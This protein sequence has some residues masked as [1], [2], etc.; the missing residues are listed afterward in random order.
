[1]NAAITAIVIVANP[2]GSSDVAEI[3][4]ASPLAAELQSIAADYPDGIP[5]ASTSQGTS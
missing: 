1:M 2:D 3:N 4:A 5:S